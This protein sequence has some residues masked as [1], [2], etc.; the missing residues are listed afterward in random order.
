MPVNTDSIHGADTAENAARSLAA[1]DTVCID[2]VVKRDG[3]HRFVLSVYLRRSQ[4]ATKLTLISPAEQFFRTRPRPNQTNA[5]NGGRSPV[6]HASEPDYQVERRY[7]EFIELRRALLSVANAEDA[8]GSRSPSDPRGRAFRCDLL[9]FL[10]HDKKRQPRHALQYATT[11]SR[12][13]SEMLAAFTVGVVA[14][15]A[16]ATSSADA[17]ETALQSAA[18][19]LADFL[20]KPRD[21]SLGII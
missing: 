10:N 9:A 16:S 19:L 13:M 4:P 3:H 14:L 1:I 6:E 5:S 15:V 12:C 18:V 17:C 2:R 11:S 8:R 21:S 20:H 7:S